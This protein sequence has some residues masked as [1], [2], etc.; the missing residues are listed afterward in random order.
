MSTRDTAC[1]VP[2]PPPGLYDRTAERMV[3]CGLLHTGRQF[4]DALDEMGFGKGDFY[5]D[6]HQRAFDL[7]CYVAYGRAAGPILCEVYTE[8]RLRKRAS[9]WLD[10]SFADGVR[11]CEFL[12]ECFGHFTSWHLKNFNLGE[13]CRWAVPT[14][15]TMWLDEPVDWTIEGLAAAASACAGKVRWLA[16]RR[17]TYYAAMEAASEAANP[18]GGPDELLDRTGSLG[19]Y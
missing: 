2:G 15:L 14:E 5:H 18:S 19:E 6:T 11:F 9:G 7:F 8:A 1:A 3:L 4:A 12:I 10:C 13:Q 16:A 17:V